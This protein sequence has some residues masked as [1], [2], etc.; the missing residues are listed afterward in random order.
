MSRHM[1]L[2]VGGLVLIS[3]SAPIRAS[4]QNGI[5]AGTVTNAETLA[6]IIAAQ[7]SIPALGLGA[8]ANSS[9]RY[10]VLGV[11]PGE[12]T[13]RVEVIGYGTQE[14]TVTVSP[15]QTVVANFQLS[16]EALGLDEIVVTGT[17]GGSNGGPS[18]TS[19]ALSKSGRRWS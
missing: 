9:G 5:V 11:P 6:P 15:G 16:I 3:L 13:V 4:A 14:Q 12:V 8:L 17:V 2:T 7:V 19:W 18:Q 1:F 10:L